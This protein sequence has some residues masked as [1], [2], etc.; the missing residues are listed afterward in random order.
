MCRKRH[1][2]FSTAPDLM[3]CHEEAFQKKKDYEGN[4]AIANRR[5]Y[6]QMAIAAKWQ[7][8]GTVRAEISDLRP[9]IPS[10][11][12]ST[13]DSLL[14][15]K[16]PHKFCTKVPNNLH[17]EH[18]FMLQTAARFCSSISGLVPVWPCNLI[19]VIFIT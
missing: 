10:Q 13:H 15:L 12:H 1:G 2:T 8:E 16:R 6:F 7:Q 4:D 5:C 9:L 3:S 18:S 19:I 11:L 17:A 14:L